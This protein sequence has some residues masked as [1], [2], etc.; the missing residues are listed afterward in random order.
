[1]KKLACLYVISTII[2][3]GCAARQEQAVIYTGPVLVPAEEALPGIPTEVQYS[4]YW[5]R[6]APD[7]DRV[8]LSLEEI[9]EFNSNNPLNGTSLVD[10][11]NLP[12]EI[13]GTSLRNHLASNAR[14]LLESTYYVTENIPL[15]M[16]ERHLIAALMDTLN[17]PD[18][19]PLRFGVM[20]RREMGK[21]WPTTIPLMSE[22]G[23]NEF[24]QGVVSS[25][26]MGEPV[27]LLHTSKDGRWSFVQTYGF[28]CWISSNAVAFGNIE[29]ARELTDKTAPLLA[30]GHRVS[31][32]G[33]PEDGVAVGNIQMGSYLPLRIAG[34]NFCEVLIPGRGEN[35]ELVAKRGY[36]R[37]G[38]DVTIG[39]LPYTLRNIYRQS[40]V[41]Y[42]RRYGW[43]GMFE[44]R[45]CSSFV[46]DVFRCFGFRLPRN[47]TQLLQAST[48]IIPLEKYDRE[49]RMEILKSAPCGITLL[50]NPGHIMI[51][52]GN[53]MGTPYVIHSFWAWRT[54]SG[55][56]SDIT[57]RVARV[58]VTDL[59]LGDGSSK[60]SFIDR[61]TH[62]TI[63]GNYII[64]AQ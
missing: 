14:H 42:G 31:V 53:V 16:S 5:I 28:T 19:I 48:V 52:L 17:V 1:M 12:E 25:I 20:L 24:D 34:N 39:F 32:Y 22:P 46:L 33:T 38:S 60:G 45:D 62:I 54:P 55:Y 36:I 4:D 26:D 21:I 41:L 18:V 44:E 57:H 37:R 43:G 35:N 9:E 47:S 63:L 29:T 59:M 7:P 40:F 2:L 56:G 23:D 8:I 15:E 58:T 64:T 61:L 6:T 3:T 10:V 30:V 49:A 51:Y 27:T 50:G 11:L 13:D